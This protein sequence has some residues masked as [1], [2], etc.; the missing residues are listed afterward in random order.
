MREETT[1]FSSYVTLT[2][3]G[4]LDTLLLSPRSFVNAPLGKLY[5]VTAG[6]DYAMADLNADQRAGLLTHASLLTVT[7]NGDYTSPTRRGKFVRD[8]LM[9]QPPPDPPA[10]LVITFPKPKPGQTLRETFNAHVANP[11]CA[12]CHTLTDPVGFGFENYDAI[13]KWR[14]T[15]AGKPVDASGEVT[16]SRDVDGPFVGAIALSKRLAGSSQVRECFM[17]K[18]FAFAEG[19]GDEMGD[20]ASVAA[21]SKAFSS[22]GTNMRELMVAVTKT[23]SFR[24]RL[25]EGQ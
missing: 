14:T 15:D 25:V 17:R 11:S 24:T 13:G 1:R 2:G 3:D 5:G 7:A 21:A 20:Q 8:Q 22:A 12:A 18:W 4:K 19:R 10:D 6:A 9:C 16:A 23:D